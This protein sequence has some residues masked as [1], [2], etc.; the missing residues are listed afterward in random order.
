MYLLT[1]TW[2]QLKSSW[3]FEK[4]KS[5]D[6]KKDDLWKKIK[7]RLFCWGNKC[8]KFW[9]ISMIL[10]SNHQTWLSRLDNWTIDRKQFIL[11]NSGYFYHPYMKIRTA[12]LMPTYLTK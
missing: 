3:N 12:D 5:Q 10:S 7:K 8:K 1:T 6:K 9:Q 4:G 2:K 11:K